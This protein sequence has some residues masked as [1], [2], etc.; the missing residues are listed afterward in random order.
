MVVLKYYVRNFIKI[1]EIELIMFGFVKLFNF[2][3]RKI[4]FFMIEK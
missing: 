3:Y 4:I 1:F 2:S